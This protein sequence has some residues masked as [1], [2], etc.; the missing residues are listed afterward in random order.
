V[1]LAGSTGLRR[2][3]LV[4]LTWSDIDLGTDAGQRA[5][6]LCAEPLRRHQDRGEPQTGSAAS[7]CREDAGRLEGRDALPSSDSDFVFPQCA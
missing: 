1:I 2:S 3:E 6:F 7:F 5:T 4:A